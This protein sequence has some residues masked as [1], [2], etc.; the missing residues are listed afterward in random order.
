MDKEE[1]P[2]RENKSNNSNEEDNKEG[3]IQFSLIY[4]KDQSNNQ[5]LESSSLKQNL[6]STQIFMKSID[7]RCEDHL[8]RFQ[9]DVEA[10]RFCQKCNISICDSCVIDF[11]IDHINLAKKKVDDY[12]ITQKNNIIELRNKVKDSLKY[13]VNEK[14][15]DKIVNSQKKLIENFFAR[16]SEESQLI[17]K[18]INN[19]QNLETDIKNSLIKSIEIFYR[20]ECFKRLQSPIEKNEILSKKIEVF[21]K[22]WSQYNK[23][24]KVVTLKNNVIENFKK[25]TENNLNIIK[26]E[27]VSFK[28]KSLDIEKKINGLIDTITQNDKMNEFNKLY[29]EMNDKYLNILKE[30]NELKYDKLTIQK[31]ED[32]KN[33]K[34]EVDYDYKELLKDKLFN[35]NNNIQ[36]NKK[37]NIVNNKNDD[38][39]NNFLDNIP[40]KNMFPPKENDNMPQVNNDDNN[41]N[42]YIN[43]LADK[44]E[45]IDKMNEFNLFQSQESG[46]NKNLN[47]NIDSLNNNKINENSYNNNNNNN[48]NI[49]KNVNYNNNMNNPNMNQ[50]NPTPMRNIPQNN[51]INKENKFEFTYELIIYLSGDKLFAYNEKVGLFCLKLNQEL[52][53]IPD[54]SRFVNLGQSALLT[55]GKT[56][57]NKLSKKCY[58]IGLLDIST[59]NNPKYTINIDEYP[60]LQEGRERHNLLFLP[61][62]NF[63]FACGGFFCNSCEYIDLYKGKWELISPL[64]KPRGN[65]SMA[66]INNSIIYI[67]GGFELKNEVNPIGNYLDDIEY[68]DVNN[69]QNGW[70]IINFSNQNTYNLG[71]TALGVIPISSNSFIICGGY[72]GKEYKKTA[73][74]IKCQDYKKPYVEQ[75]P[76]INEPTIFTNN[77]FCKIRKSY[78]N[79][80]FKGQMY[81]FDQENR[82]FGML[83]MNSSL[84]YMN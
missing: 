24:E 57:E 18:K 83:N 11:H 12:F 77:M 30:I 26:E 63:V 4:Q 62:K 76:D 17:I 73:Y 56:K 15:I 21:F 31:L 71:L 27:M 38:L 54:K 49:P 29:S 59:S 55:G 43:N 72:D 28:G 13:K 6:F 41:S 39:K 66:Y 5:N 78:F 81:G 35:N 70:N 32:I 33:K 36:D 3:E 10:T 61:D 22:E 20:D 84:K 8:T 67:I 45:E 68:F 23:R 53:Y 69:F 65:A 50:I 1:I 48:N 40:Q 16:R 75:Y 80:D 9:E 19:L 74:I 34:V 52:R 42:S 14:E 79:F 60:D 44:L 46:D 64:H 58:L 25:E 37:E 47:D 82:R 7:L 2:D 51:P